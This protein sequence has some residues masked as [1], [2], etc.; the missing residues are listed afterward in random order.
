MGIMKTSVLNYTVV[1]QPDAD[2]V[3]HVIVPALPGCVTFG[4]SFEEA[5]EKAK[6]VIELWLEEL[7]Q[8]DKVFPLNAQRPWIGDIRVHLPSA[9][10]RTS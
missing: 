9:R 1:F 3:F 4:Y 8:E 7:A 10:A 6:E 2:G 5:Q